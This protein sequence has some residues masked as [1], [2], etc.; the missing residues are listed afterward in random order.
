MDIS[1]PGGRQLHRAATPLSYHQ[2]MPAWTCPQCDRTFG[3]RNQSH[4]CV[5]SS[6]LDDYFAGRPPLQREICDAIIG[7]LRTLGPVN[8]DPVQVV[9]LFKRSSTFAE[10]RAKRDRLTLTFLLSRAVQSP[11]FARAVPTSANRTA[12]FVDLRHA[13][14]IDDE[15]VD[16]LTESYF[17]SPR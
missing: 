7:H 13:D 17:D 15:L 10:V 16:W 4:T 3:R 1:P 6:T 12:Y 2:P 5:P 9:V 14:D 11:R 8:V